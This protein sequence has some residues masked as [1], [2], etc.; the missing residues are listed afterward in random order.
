MNLKTRDVIIILLVALMVFSLFM[1]STTAV[2]FFGFLLIAWI[3]EES[4]K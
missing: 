1:Y 4:L 3:L 2:D